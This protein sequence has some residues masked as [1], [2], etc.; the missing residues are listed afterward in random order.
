MENI[1]LVPMCCALVSLLMIVVA[2]LIQNRSL[3]RQLDEV[4]W[5]VADYDAFYKSILKDP[6]SP[7]SRFHAA[8]ETLQFIRNNSVNESHATVKYK[9]IQSESLALIRYSGEGAVTFPKPLSF[10]NGGTA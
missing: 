1:Y 5:P 2:L 8:C 4:Y 10:E 6:D 3:R 9:A 7:T